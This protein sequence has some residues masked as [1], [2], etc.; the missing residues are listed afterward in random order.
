[1]RNRS[2]EHLRHELKALADLL[3]RLQAEDHAAD[4]PIV[5]A[6]LA[7]LIERR[8]ELEAVRRFANRNA[9]PS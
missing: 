8:N 2:E 6:T 3:E 9:K 5:L 1:M 7:M 4:S